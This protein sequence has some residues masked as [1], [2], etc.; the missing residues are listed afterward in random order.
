MCNTGTTVRTSSET[1]G[2]D[3]AQDELMRSLSRLGEHILGE[4]VPER[5]LRVIRRLRSTQL[6]CD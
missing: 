1:Y 4:D 5:L 6:S 3:P 2:G